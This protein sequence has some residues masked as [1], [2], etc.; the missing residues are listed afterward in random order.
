MNRNVDLEMLR[1]HIKSVKKKRGVFYRGEMLA[2][3]YNYRLSF[4][5]DHFTT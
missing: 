2:I 3:V 5:C 4:R 1:A